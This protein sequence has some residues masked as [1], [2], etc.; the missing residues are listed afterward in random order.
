[1]EHGAMKERTPVICVVEDDVAARNSLQLLLKFRGFAVTAHDSAVSFL[2]NHDPLQP[3]CLLLDIRMPGMNGLE[4]Q[5]QLNQRGTLAPI[6][7]IT[8]PADVAM[9]LEAMQRGAFGF[10]Q[11]PFR[12][13]ELLDRVQ[14]AVAKD[15]AI[16]EELRGHESICQRL[17][18]L[19]TAEHDMLDLVTK[20]ALIKSSHTS[21]AS[22]G[23]RSNSIARA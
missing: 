3:G 16:R 8:S 15:C 7:F 23:A 1:M 21:Q 14:R 6:I 13:Q 17:E 11:K 4:L 5:Q 22:V 20:G 10:L 19:T 2:A 9:A 12:D 18:S